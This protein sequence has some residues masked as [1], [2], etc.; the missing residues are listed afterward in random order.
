MACG[1]SFSLGLSE[2]NKV[3]HWGNFKYS[4]NHKDHKDLTE[5][6]FIEKLETDSIVDIA[7]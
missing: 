2:L 1:L 7:S 3:S 5:P 6:Y 4:L